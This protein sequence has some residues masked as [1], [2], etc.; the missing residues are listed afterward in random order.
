[1]KTTCS[2]VLVLPVII[3]C[4]FLH[5]VSGSAANNTVRGQSSTSEEGQRT[6]SSTLN[7]HVGEKRDLAIQKHSQKTRLYHKENIGQIMQ[8]DTSLSPQG[9]YIC[10][11]RQTIP[12][13][14]SQPCTF[15]FKL[16]SWLQQIIKPTD[17][18]GFRRPLQPL[19]GAGPQQYK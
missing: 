1:M 18:S 2:Q 19:S 7:G 6:L 8:R 10:N 5:P 12:D 15:K 9:T 4:N 13:N 14:Q 17:N 16:Y 3:Q 11:N